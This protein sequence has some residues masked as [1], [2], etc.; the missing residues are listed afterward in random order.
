MEREGRTG[1]YLALEPES[2]LELHRLLPRLAE[3]GFRGLNVTAPFKETVLRF[4]HQRAPTAEAVGSANT[5]TFEGSTVRADN[6]DLGAVQQRLTELKESGVWGGEE[7]VVAG[8]GGAARA[9]VV[10]GRDLG[11]GVAIWGRRASMEEKLAREFGVE[12]WNSTRGRPS[13]LVIHATPVGRGSSGGSLPIGE[14]LA[15][16]G[17]LL[18]FVYAPTDRSL[19]EIA[20]ARRASYESGL[21]LL[22]YQAAASYRIW[23]GAPLSHEIVESTYRE[24][25]LCE[26]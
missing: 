21:R 18:D 5:L 15:P 6:T 10:A 14:M 17:H 1:L 7:L 24:A 23:W 26:A 9:A 20:L 3:G 11:A 22:L 13:S 12:R 2:D 25:A 8:T 19:Q 4:A 16:S